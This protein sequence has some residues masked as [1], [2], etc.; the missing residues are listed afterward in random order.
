MIR[1]A[2]KYLRLTSW[3]WFCFLSLKIR[4]DGTGKEWAAMGTEI[5]TAVDVLHLELLAYQ[6]LMVSVAN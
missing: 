3:P 6:V 2:Y 4:L 1:Q 5:V